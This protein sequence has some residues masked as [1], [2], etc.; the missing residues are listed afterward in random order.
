MSEA[1]G[2]NGNGISRRKKATK[3]QIRRTAAEQSNPFDEKVLRPQ[4]FGHLIRLVSLGTFPSRGRLKRCVPRISSLLL[5][6][7]V[8]AKR[9]DEV[10]WGGKA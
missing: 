10:F 1:V 8:G 7:K 5:E 3:P 9:S 2:R 6:E 4:K